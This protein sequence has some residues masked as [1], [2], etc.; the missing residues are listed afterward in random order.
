MDIRDMLESRGHAIAISVSAALLASAAAWAALGR[1]GEREALL[2][3]AEKARAVLVT[4]PVPERAKPDFSGIAGAW[5]AGAV[6][7][8]QGKKAFVSAPKPRVTAR[9]IPS[10]TTEPGPVKLVLPAV[11]VPAATASPGRVVLKWSAPAAGAK[12]A[13]IAE[14]RIWRQSAGEREASVVAK[15]RG[16]AVEWADENVRPR[17]TYEYRLQLVTAQPTADGAQESARSA[18]ATATSPSDADIAFTGGSESAA[19]IVVKKWSSGEW[20]EERFVVRPKD[21]AAGRDG[22]IGGVIVKA[23]QRVDFSCGFVL[24][25]IHRETR[26]YFIMVPE[27]RFDGKVVQL[28]PVRRELSREWL[29]IEFTDDAGTRRRL[30][31]NDPLPE[32]AEPLTEADR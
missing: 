13:A 21:E 30:W 4:S 11:P 29:R 9:V 20:R 27:R 15:L 7:A 17:A 19:M 3:R 2:A 8:P 25:S 32:G 28:V 18:A 6:A 31:Q 24:H 12:I 5:D 26:R 23:N 14:I 16:D 10:A 22:V 1:D